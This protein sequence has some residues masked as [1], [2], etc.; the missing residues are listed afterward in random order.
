MQ[1]TNWRQQR[2]NQK[3]YIDEGQDNTMAK[4][5]MVKKTNN[6]LKYTTQKT[7]GWVKRTSQKTMDKLRYSVKVSSDRLVTLDNCFMLLWPLWDIFVTN[8]HGLIHL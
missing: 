7:K 2:G 1:N 4:N 6:D 5:E 3:S 8:D